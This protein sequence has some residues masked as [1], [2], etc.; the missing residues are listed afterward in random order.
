[1]KTNN[2]K[3]E[4]LKE[5]ISEINNSMPKVIDKSLYKIDDETEMVFPEIRHI[6]KPNIIND[7]EC[8]LNNSENYDYILSLENELNEYQIDFFN[9]YSIIKL[10]PKNNEEFLID[11]ILR[12]NPEL[13]QLF[14]S[15]SIRKDCINKIKD[16]YSIK[17]YPKVQEDIKLFLN[18]R[19]LETVSERELVIVELLFLSVKTFDFDLYKYFFQ[20]I[21]IARP[22]TNQNTLNNS[23]S[24]IIKVARKH[25]NNDFIIKLLE[26]EKENHHDL[27]TNF[28]KSKELKKSNHY[29]DFLNKC[30]TKKFN[31]ELVFHEFVVS[32]IK[33][34]K[35]YAEVLN[36]MGDKKL[37]DA[38]LT[39]KSIDE[40]WINYT[41]TISALLIPKKYQK[42]I[43]F[44]V[45]SKRL[46]IPSNKLYNYYKSARTESPSKQAYLN[47]MKSDEVIFFVSN[48]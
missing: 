4:I 39:I 33:A 36:K 30:S 22:V 3:Q 18:G 41:N 20:N 25:F 34:Y 14:L 1:M 12:F 26:K 5:L 43:P 27:F 7:I 38:L 19:I 45:L 15:D 24:V 37:I 8:F 46:S 16:E 2:V 21:K 40:S 31:G 23:Y 9:Q 42:Y 13:K 11:L 10:K 17:D 32:M 47:F 29:M 35:L 28:N 44:L 6:K 48:I